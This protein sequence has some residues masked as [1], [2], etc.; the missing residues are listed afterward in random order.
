VVDYYQQRVTVGTIPPC[1][2]MDSQQTMRI[3]ACGGGGGFTPYDTNWIW[4]LIH[5][6]GGTVGRDNAQGLAY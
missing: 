2:I 3:S 4:F 5:S 1:L 6:S